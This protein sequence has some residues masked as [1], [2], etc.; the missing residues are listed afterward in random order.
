M[1][2]AS[3]SAALDVVAPCVHRRSS[4]AASPCA[5]GIEP[6]CVQGETV[7]TGSAAVKSVIL[8]STD[9]GTLVAWMCYALQP[10]KRDDP[11]PCSALHSRPGRTKK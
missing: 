3:R 11:S 4:A 5:G 10:D 2:V 6:S 8:P 1:T 7:H 9:L